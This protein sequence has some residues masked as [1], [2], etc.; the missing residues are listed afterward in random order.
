M[1]GVC[2]VPVCL[3]LFS[4]HLNGPLSMNPFLL[5]GWQMSLGNYLNEVPAAL[6][7]SAGRYL[8]LPLSDT[9]NVSALPRCHRKAAIS[10]TWPSQVA[11]DAPT[12]TRLLSNPLLPFRLASQKL[13]LVLYA[14][15]PLPQAAP[16][17]HIIAYLT[18][19]IPIHRCDGAEP[20]FR[21]DAPVSSIPSHFWL[22]RL[23]GPDMRRCM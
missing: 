9:R 13:L 8:L 19:Q 22:R 1:R 21:P 10:V 18:Y 15:P 20:G 14:I 17:L 12:R 3:A 6:S 11:P 7:T 16:S 23:R 2:T 4:H 5:A